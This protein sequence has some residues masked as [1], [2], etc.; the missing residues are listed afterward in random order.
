MRLDETIPCRKH[1]QGVSSWTQD[2]MQLPEHADLI[3][4]V[5]Q[6]LF[7]D[8]EVET[9][10][11]ERQSLPRIGNVKAGAVTWVAQLKIVLHIVPNRVGVALVEQRIH[12]AS[13][14][15]AEV[16]NVGVL[17]ELDT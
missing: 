10:I 14:A 11:L 9:I 15:T 4:Y 1:M 2:A 7:G 5:L 8:N 13:S 12:R 6:H 16:Q 17:G 3:H